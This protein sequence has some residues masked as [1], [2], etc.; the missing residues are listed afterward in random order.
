M[1]AALIAVLAALVAVGTAHASPKRLPQLAAAPR[2]ALTQ[3][4]ERGQIDE[5]TYALE[6]AKSL[7]DRR[8]VASVYGPVASPRRLDATLV[9]RDLAVRLP[10]LAPGE[11]KEAAALL[12]R[13]D[14][15]KPPDGEEGYKVPQAPPV[16][17]AHFCVHYVTSTADA[18]AP[19]DADANGLPDQ[20][21]LTQRV[22]EEVWAKEVD[23]E[24]F[25]APKSDE[26]SLNHGPDGKLDV[27]LA[28]IGDDSLYGY[29]TTDDPAL[30]VA[31]NG[32]WDTSAYCVLDNDY[33]SSEFFGAATGEQALQVTAAHEFFHAVQ[34][35][36]DV[37]EDRWF[38]EGTA[39][40]MEDEVYD[41]VNDNYQYLESSALSDPTVPLDL[42]TA[43]LSSPSSGF[44]YG[45]FVFFRY[46]SESL[47][48]PAVI[49][50]AWEFADGSKGALDQYSFQAIGSA[51]KESGTTARAAFARFGAVNVTPGSFYEEGSAYPT[52][53]AKRSLTLS[54]VGR[55]TLGK[56]KLGHLTTWYVRF[57]PSPSLA[58]AQL[59]V[60][61]DLPPAKR[62][63]AA[64]LVVIDKAGTPTV[65][66]VTL[67]RKGDGTATVPF[68]GTDVSAV[69]LVLSNA[70]GRFRCWRRSA[71]SC[72]G[73][74]LDD[75]L[76]YRYQAKVLVPPP[77]APAEV[78]TGR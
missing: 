33:S 77:S 18:P 63:S 42:A 6:R 53:P 23:E 62:G 11:R 60:T 50:R 17:T 37:L 1:R 15:P 27:Y 78:A 7:F 56:A 43:N 30:A 22:L 66:P 8:A 35:A 4:L 36:Y 20:V 68:S 73:T 45:A 72:Q 13:P 16:C 32:P 25:R 38:M 55:P 10:R 59:Q 65:V 2:D 76:T 69:E 52:P 40:W 3:A 19:V 74:S 67:N 57:A 24:G 49:R 34:F 28:N 54:G 71:F 31:T 39:V 58:G 70:S 48:T 61:L 44:Q 21:D 5:G 14:D 51:L 26:T 75:G 47:Q 9:L 29:C 12:A 41:D 46:L 64:S